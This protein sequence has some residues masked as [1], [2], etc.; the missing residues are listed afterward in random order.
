[1]EGLNIVDEIKI[2]VIIPVYN[3]SKY[4]RQ[5]INSVL[6]QT[7]KNIEVICIDDGS[8]DNSLEILKEYQ[9]KDNRII[10]CTQEN[11]GAAVARN[12]GLD[13]A[14]GDYIAFM[15]PDD[16]YPDRDVLFSIYERACDNNALIAGGSLALDRNESH[17]KPTYE[18]QDER[19]FDKDAFIKYEDYQY[20]FY[21]QRF[22]YKKKINR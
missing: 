18:T 8:I 16:Y 21:Y 6:G 11:S 12:K 19:F 2:S 17:Y 7:L 22:I 9:I 13:I 15:D 20:D 4:L 1:M 3:A 5:C 14:K 10:V